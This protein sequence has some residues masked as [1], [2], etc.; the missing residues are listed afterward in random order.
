MALEAS[1]GGVVLVVKEEFT[2]KKGLVLLVMMSFDITLNEVTEDKSD[3]GGV[4]L[5]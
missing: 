1:M 3:D 4:R 2:E 5:I